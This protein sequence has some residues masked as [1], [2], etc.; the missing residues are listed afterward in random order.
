MEFRPAI[1]SDLSGLV[2][3]LTRAFYAY[4]TFTMALRSEF[5]GTTGY[6]KFLNDYF[7][8][9]LLLYWRKGKLVVAEE[10]GQLIGVG[11]MAAPN[12]RLTWW[13]YF[14]SGG[15]RL[16]WPYLWHRRGRLAEISRADG[17]AQPSQ[18]TWTLVYFAV[19]PDFQGRGVGTRL[20]NQQI[21]PTVRAAGAK[22]L[23]L[24]TNTQRNV[25]Y[26]SDQSFQVVTH[27][28]VNS[29]G[30]QVFNWQLT[31]QVTMS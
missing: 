4:P 21:I 25:R 12:V 7:V 13:D 19:D 1:R 14:R 10:Q 18:E 9:D 30:V 24:V 8:M 11:V 23:T 3:L 28:Q 20:L 5:R 16:V 17:M 15:L 22:S 29:Q 27:H 31:R 2:Q 6:D 26:Y